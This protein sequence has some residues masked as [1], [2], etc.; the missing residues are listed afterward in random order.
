MCF[1][2]NGQEGSAHPLNQE[3]FNLHLIPH[4]RS[5]QAPVTI[6]DVFIWAVLIGNYELA[7]L[8][9]LTSAAT[10]SGEDSSTK[11]AAG[12]GCRVA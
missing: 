8:M 1:R 5:L 9:W 10:S 3:S 7:E 11:C 2:T 4:N 12:R 6:D